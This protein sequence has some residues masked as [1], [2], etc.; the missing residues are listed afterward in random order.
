MTTVNI[1]TLIFVILFALIIALLAVIILLL[2]SEKT[3]RIKYLL[4]V[5]TLFIMTEVLMTFLFF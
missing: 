2:L 1:T 5:L 4:I 3:S